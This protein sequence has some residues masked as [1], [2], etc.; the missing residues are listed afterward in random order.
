MSVAAI[1]RA[2]PPPQVQPATAAPVRGDNDGDADDKGGGV[3]ATP[4]TGMGSVV[5]IDA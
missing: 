3:R 1:T 5:D 2:S 4:Q